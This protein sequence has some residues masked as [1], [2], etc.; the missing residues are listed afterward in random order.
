[1]YLTTSCET[2]RCRKL[3]QSV[4]I[5]CTRATP[6][7]PFDAFGLAGPDTIWAAEI[8]NVGGGTD[9]CP[10][11]DNGMLRC[12]DEVRYLCAFALKV[13]WDFT[14]FSDVVEVDG[15]GHNVVS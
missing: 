12:L 14:V 11:E 6:R 15:V 13:F 4:G 5:A 9:S 3:W 10:G 1:M 7:G 2:R 8:W